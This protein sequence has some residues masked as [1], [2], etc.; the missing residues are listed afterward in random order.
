MAKDTTTF[1][2]KFKLS[3]I[4]SYE[5]KKWNIRVNEYFDKLV[6]TQEKYKKNYIEWAKN[7]ETNK[8]K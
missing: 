4:P 5:R 3:P 8:A 6:S 7:A 2:K 1:C